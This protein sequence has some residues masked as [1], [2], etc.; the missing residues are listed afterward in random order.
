M[1]QQPATEFTIRTVRE[2]SERLLVV[3]TGQIDY[4]CAV[5]FEQCLAAEVCDRAA[6]VVELDLAGVSFCDCAG[7]NVLLR[8]REY[9]AAHGRGLRIRAVSRRVARLMDLTDTSELLRGDLDGRRAGV[10]ARDRG[11]VRPPQ[12]DVAEKAADLTGMLDQRVKGD[13]SRFK[14][15]IEERGRETGGRRGRISPT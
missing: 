15:F 4:D 1:S 6:A 13:L 5:E 10:G 14:D 11:F 9:A 7:L 2:S 12:L 8:M 3:V